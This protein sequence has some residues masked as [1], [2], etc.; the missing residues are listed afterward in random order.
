M[1]P[2]SI[3]SFALDWEEQRPLITFQEDIHLCG[4]NRE[5]EEISIKWFLPHG[6]GRGFHLINN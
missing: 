2:F 4:C 6:S 1:I 5:S 3:H